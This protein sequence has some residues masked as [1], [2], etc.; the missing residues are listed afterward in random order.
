[1]LRMTKAK[2]IFRML[3][4][5]PMFFVLLIIPWELIL[6]LKLISDWLYDDHSRPLGLALKIVAVIASIL[7]LVAMIAFFIACLVEIIRIALGKESKDR[8]AASHL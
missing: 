2:N 5:I 6:G 1:M 7:L 3:F 8:P 4:A